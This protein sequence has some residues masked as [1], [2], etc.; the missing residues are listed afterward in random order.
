MFDEVSET[1]PGPT[2]RL[3][4]AVALERGV[5]L[6][7]GS[8]LEKSTDR[9]KSFNTSVLFDLNGEVAVCYRKAHLF[10]VDVP[11]EVTY[12][13]SAAI[14]PGSEL[15][16]ARVG[17]FR[18]GL[19]I[20]FDV[21]FPELYRALALGGASVFSVPA[22][23]SAVTGPVHWEVLLRA[24][25]I[26]NH[27]FVIAATQAGTTKEGLATHGHAMVIDPWGAILAQST[28]EDEQVVIADIDL[29][30]VRRRRSE[31]DV[32]TLRRP[33]LYGGSSTT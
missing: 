27:A 32:L 13:E 20:C 18:M 14:A 15:V 8:M 4:G 11:G 29:R 17:V 7:L 31:I 5:T 26:E 19:T 24:R 30:E 28:T 22:A 33:E 16:V 1:I 6:H 2:T 12:K 10:D 21:R 23:F 9:D 3:L 25:A